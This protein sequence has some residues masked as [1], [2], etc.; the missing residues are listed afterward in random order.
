MLQL[1]ELG[2]VRPSSSPWAANVVLSRK[3]DGSIRTCYDARK[4]NKV[5]KQDRREIIGGL[6]DSFAARWINPEAPLPYPS[7]LRLM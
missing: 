6:F 7:G 3:P 4:I 2:I 5:T 1:L